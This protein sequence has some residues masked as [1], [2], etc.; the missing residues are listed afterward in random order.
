MTSLVPKYLVHG[1]VGVALGVA[2]FGVH[3]D[4]LEGG[5]ALPLAPLSIG[6]EMQLAPLCLQLVRLVRLQM[7]QLHYNTFHMHLY[8]GFD[9]FT[10]L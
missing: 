2:H 4:P 6:S 1:K 10:F 7:G 9:V 3:S 5:P 8:N